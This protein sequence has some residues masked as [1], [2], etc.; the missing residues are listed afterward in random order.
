MTSNKII[1]KNH[2]KEIRK[3]CDRL[4]YAIDNTHNLVFTSS[5]SE[6]ISELARPIASA[7]FNIDMVLKDIKTR[8]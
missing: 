6:L 1:V 7:V 5:D 8:G 4:L 2:L 3:H